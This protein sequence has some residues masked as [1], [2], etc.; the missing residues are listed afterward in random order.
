ML[1]FLITRHRR[2]SP[3]NVSE[4]PRLS[5][6]DRRDYQA[7]LM[8]QVLRQALTVDV[9]EYDQAA[10]ALAKPERPALLHRLAQGS[11]LQ[12]CALA[13]SIGRLIKNPID[14]VV[15]AFLASDVEEDTRLWADLKA[16]LLSLRRRI[17]AQLARAQRDKSDCR[18]EPKSETSP[19]SHTPAFRHWFWDF[20][21]M[22]VS[23]IWYAERASLPDVAMR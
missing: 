19:V 12:T 6:P 22:A 8:T 2:A 7:L 10:P 11:L 17:S 9:Y 13:V 3:P 1:A 18:I 15:G 14:P 16:W 20:S 5:L 23:V 21:A 4:Q